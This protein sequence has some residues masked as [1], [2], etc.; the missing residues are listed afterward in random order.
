MKKVLS[1]VLAIALV[2][3]LSVVAFAEEKL[4]D[5]KLMFFSASNWSQYTADTTMADLVAALQT[6]GA[7]LVI[8]RSNEPTDIDWD[9]GGYEKFCITDSWW[10][11]RIPN[12]A[13]EEINVVRLGTGKHTIANMTAAGAPYDVSLDCVLDDGINV[14][15]DGAALAAILVDC[16]FTAGGPAIE[17]TSNTSSAD[18]DV[19]NMAVVIPDEPIAAPEAPVEE[20]APAEDVPAVE[21]TP[22]VEET[23]AVDAPADEAP[24]ETG[25][26]LAIVPMIVALAAVVVS[27]KR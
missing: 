9:N 4:I 21:D 22:A 19:V 14:W 18:Y 11:G 26:A 25:L 17:V 10:A 2:L 16:G 3:S 20:E 15:Y 7:Y 5:E 23:P 6:P 24:A 13:G 27:K 12:D 8:T 1:I